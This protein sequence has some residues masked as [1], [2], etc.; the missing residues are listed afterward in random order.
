MATR[1]AGHTSAVESRFGERR[2]V[3]RA[4]LGAATARR[5]FGAALR[6]ASMS[7]TRILV[8]AALASLATG[9][10]AESGAPLPTGTGAFA[11]GEASLDEEEKADTGWV[12]SIDAA[13][14]EVD[15][16]ADVEGTSW[17]AHD[18]LEVAQF[19]LTY[20]RTH[21]DVYLQS[22]AEDYAH[23]TE[24]IEW[25]VDGEWK[26]LETTPELRTLRPT[27]FRMRGVSALV[28]NPGSRRTLGQRSFHAI[29]P[30]SPG[31][32][33]ADVGTRCG[34]TTGHIQPDAQVYWYVW[35]PE[36]TGCDARTQ[37][38]EVR[39]SR[40]LPAGERVYPE[41]DRLMEDGQIDALVMFGQVGDGALS[42]SDYAFDLVRDFE[43]ELTGAGFTKQDDAPLGLRYAR[44]QNGV[45]AIVDIYTPREFAGLGDWAHIDD[46]DQGV[47]SHEIVVWNGHSMLGASDFWSRDAIYD[48]DSATRYQIFL[49]NGCLGYEYYINPII[50]GKQGWA[51]VDV[52]SNALE[53]PFA[54][55]V[56]ETS[57]ALAMIFKGAERS[58]RGASWQAILSRM[59]DIAGSDAIYGA[60]GVRDNAFRPGSVTR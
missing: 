8:A 46:F 7:P 38:I 27:H 37:D 4:L 33:M 14:V 36:K 54:I 55:M 45:K 53:T 41:L 16:E 12:S 58:G 47:R 59:S 22:L 60:S 25:L 40:V 6:R 35:D 30:V 52:I 24:R 5:D 50:E 26:T 17:D 13:E 34:D 11:E 1:V 28:V 2:S 19:A 51:N 10:V 42:D 56:E 18:P 3:D 32:L 57:T 31:T 20:L 29:V 43:S 9:C 15:I 44:T 48:G 39:V 21:R 23:G 49:Y